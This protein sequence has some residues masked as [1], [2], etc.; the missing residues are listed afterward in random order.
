MSTAEDSTCDATILDCGRPR[1]CQNDDGH[2]PAIRHRSVLRNG[3]NIMDWTDD[4]KDATPAS[5]SPPRAVARAT[6][7]TVTCIP[8]DSAPDAH[9]W[10]LYVEEKRDGSW[11]VT[12]GFGWMDGELTFQD[13]PYPACCHDFDTAMRLA[14][15]AAPKVVINGR[16][17]VEALAI[18]AEWKARRAAA[19]PPEGGQQ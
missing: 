5:T 15:E 11:V 4:A 1:R 7:Y 16:T 9:V 12:D 14:K 3:S 6:R 2:Y 18:A 17:V 8:P 10:A 13:R 19:V